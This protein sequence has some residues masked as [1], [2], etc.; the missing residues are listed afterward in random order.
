MMHKACNRKGEMPYCFPRSSIK[1]QGHT[2]QNITDFDPNCAFPDYRPVAAFKPLRFALFL[3]YSKC[4]LSKERVDAWKIM[5]FSSLW[6][7]QI[8]QSQMLVIFIITSSIV[9]LQAYTKRA[10]W[11]GHFVWVVRETVLG[12]WISL[13]RD[14]A[15][16]C[17]SCKGN[18]FGGLDLIIS[19][20]SSAD[21]IFVRSLFRVL[22]I[23]SLW[24]A[25]LFQVLYINT[26]K[27]RENS[28][29]TQTTPEPT[30]LSL[31]GWL[32][33][34]FPPTPPPT[35]PPHPW[36]HSKPGLSTLIGPLRPYCSQ[37]LWSSCSGVSRK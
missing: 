29:V 30:L 23:D 24:L 3:T 18:S 13:S 17:M 2:G 11:R 9:P 25:N 22:I 15:A 32:R 27:H 36:P 14:E 26:L 5:C 19:R 16:I 31:G 1:F 4:F 20:W 21:I 7:H 28:P 10:L 33:D 6:H 12:V 8:Q 37:A 34:K 35:P